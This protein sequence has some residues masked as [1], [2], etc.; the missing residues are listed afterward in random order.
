MKIRFA[1]AY[2]L[3]SYTG[4]LIFSSCCTSAPPFPNEESTDRLEII[5]THIHLYDTN[6]SQG[7]D[8]PPVTDKVL[9]R[10]VL[11]EHFDEV[12]DRV[13]IASTVIVEASSRVEDNQWMLDLIKNDPDRY[14]ALVGNLPIGT[15]EFPSLL[16][17]FSKDSTICGYTNEAT[18]GR[19]YFFH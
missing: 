15:D 10:P 5:D 18:T 8:W 2:A 9:Y 1:N 19:G 16:D 7:V 4:A 12:A 6:R 3:L 14:L 11:T 13:G 17:R